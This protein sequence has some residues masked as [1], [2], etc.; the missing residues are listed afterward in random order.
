MKTPALVTALVAPAAQTEVDLGRR[1]TYLMLFRLVLI[2]LV[3]GATILLG[4]LT[5]VD[6]GTP[7]AELLFG[8]IAATYVLTIV[9]ALAIS[10]VVNRLRFAYIQLALDLVIATLLVHITGGAQS[11]YTFF[12][13]VTIIG[14]ATVRF[15]VGAIVVALVSITLYATASLAGWFELLP[16][17]SGQRILPHEL[18][19]VEL[20]RSM[21]LNVAAFSAVGFLAI[22]LGGQ[23]QRTSASLESEREA[24]ADLFTLHE[25]IV[26]S[27]T[28]GLLTVDDNGYVLTMN[29]AARDILG[30]PVDIK[31]RTPLA[32][33]APRLAEALRPLEQREAM[34]RG[35]IE[36][37]LEDG[38]TLVLGVSVSPLVDHLD[39]V[40]G[41]IV[42]FQDLTEMRR[43]EAQ[44]QRAE[45]LATIGTIAA[46]VAH[47]LRNPLAAISGSIELLRETE[48]SDRTALMHIVTRE[49]GRLDALSAELLDYSNPR[50]RE[51]VKFDLVEL[52]EETLRM[53]GQDKGVEGVEVE[54][55]KP[56]GPIE[57]TADPA[58]L[59]QVLWNLLRNASEAARDGGGHVTVALRLADAHAHIDIVDDGPG[60]PADAV[61]HIFDPFFT[62]RNTGT[63]LGLA[64]VQS[65]IA[66]HN[67][68]IDVLT[69]VG[70]GT[71]F[72][73]RLPLE[74]EV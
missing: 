59:R 60:I 72:A 10:R 67:G 52:T 36:L 17:P 29:H 49:V 6:L 46:G 30:L 32:D 4:W 26:R 13:P 18:S 42:N 71:T 58:K 27:L 68:E 61:R 16:L 38:R 35:E 3:L 74:D 45:R 19:A 43:M 64:I 53:F 21:G 11:A 39:K 14:A 25:D 62:T 8:I 37:T 7:N 56:A 51:S 69:A 55:R 48:G 12:Y 33:V 28:S 54:L 47:E 20:V 44:V 65:L 70:K 5:D 34:R 22:N 57:L 24:A 50:P 9:Y 15:R 2:S 41:R 23:L 40:N 63:G 66:E 31:P 1:I 73:L